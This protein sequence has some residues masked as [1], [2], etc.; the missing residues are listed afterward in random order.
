MAPTEPETTWLHRLERYEAGGWQ[1]LISRQLPLGPQDKVTPEIR[2]MVRGLVRANPV[3]RSPGVRDELAAMGH[4]LSE[5]T[6]RKVMAEEGVSRPVGRP[7]GQVRGE[8][9]ELAGAE[10]LEALDLELGA[11]ESLTGALQRVLE[12]LP[13]PE[14][15]AED[16]AHRDERGRLTAEYNQP[17]PR[18]EPELG[19]KF[20]TV[21][22]RRIGKDLAG[23]R[24][25]PLGRSGSLQRACVEHG[26]RRPDRRSAS[27]A[28]PGGPVCGRRC[29]GDCSHAIAA[30][31]A[32]RASP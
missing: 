19:A 3:Y 23:M 16:T 10:L 30:Q 13:E 22:R 9:L 11:T 7:A 5:S 31:P 25:A 6:V 15:P 32:P 12:A 1:R 14:T 24:A 4:E 17:G 8:R 27:R 2:A 29:A 26:R 28:G 21:A 20:D 18:T